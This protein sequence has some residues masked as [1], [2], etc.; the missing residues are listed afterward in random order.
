[1]V[2]FDGVQVSTEVTPMVTE[3]AREIEQARLAAGISI[4]EMLVSVTRWGQ[5]AS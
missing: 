2:D 4:E 1:M 3:L 5:G